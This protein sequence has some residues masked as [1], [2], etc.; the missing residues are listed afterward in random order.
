MT[1]PMESR[2]QC[3]T[4][5]YTTPFLTFST[6]TSRVVAQRPSAVIE[7]AVAQTNMTLCESC[8]PR[9]WAHLA[10]SAYHIQGALEKQRASLLG[11]RDSL[12]WM[13][14][15][16]NPTLNSWQRTTDSNCGLV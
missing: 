8:V 6:A 15:F 16:S 10:S 14:T 1:L 12:D 9:T 5:V 2:F 13:I 7:V 11:L 3:P 4:R